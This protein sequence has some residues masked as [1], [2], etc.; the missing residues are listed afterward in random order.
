MVVEA[1]KMEHPVT[2]PFDGIV[3]AVHVTAGQSVAMDAA[4]A[5]VEAPEAQA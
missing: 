2:A 5:V 3:A 1:M 4:L